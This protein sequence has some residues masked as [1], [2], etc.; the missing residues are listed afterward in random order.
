MTHE[1]SEMGRTVSDIKKLCP[2]STVTEGL[3]IRGSRVKESKGN[4]MKW[5]REKKIVK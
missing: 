2:K 4:V 1:G 3:A 5:L